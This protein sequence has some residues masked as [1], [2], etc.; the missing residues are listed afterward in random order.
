MASRFRVLVTEIQ[1]LDYGLNPAEHFADG[2][3]ADFLIGNACDQWIMQQQ[4][5]LA[6]R[7]YAGSV[8]SSGKIQR[9]SIVANSNLDGAQYAGGLKYGGI[10]KANHARR[11]IQ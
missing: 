11:F 6:E 4:W 9:A 2:N 1:R 7:A 5:A 8:V 3:F 10:S